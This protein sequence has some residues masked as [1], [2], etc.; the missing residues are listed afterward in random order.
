ML[1]VFVIRHLPPLKINS[2]QFQSLNK[3][4]H[5]KDLLYLY[6]VAVYLNSEIGKS[7]SLRGE[8][9]GLQKHITLGRTKK[10]PIYLLSKELQDKIGYLYLNSITIMK[11]AITK[12]E[13]AENK[14]ISEIGLNKLQIKEEKTFYG[15]FND[16]E[17]FERIDADFFQPKYDE[18]INKIT[19]YKNGYSI[20]DK[21]FK[22]NKD[23]F[24]RNEDFIYNY[25]EIGSVNIFDVKINP[26]VK[27]YS[28]LPDNCKIKLEKNNLLISKVRPYRGA[29]SIIEDNKENLVGSTAFTI[30]KEKTKYKKE[31]LLLLLRT[32]FYKELMMKY[33]VGTSYPVVK[34]DNIVNLPI[35]LIPVEVQNEL[36]KEINDFFKL[37]NEAEKNLN[38][39]KSLLF[40]EINKEL[41]L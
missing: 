31:I 32:S 16:I 27:K 7:L 12:Y 17:K 14:L 35:P 23:K 41:N 6:Y 11:E 38:D 10:I 29:I 1:Y 22:V 26:L 4:Q 36:S 3:Q 25:V 8:S 9:G 19:S 13:E 18:I 2:S 20:I 21:E 40:D 28:D 15:N 39:A 33:N 5:N 30:L 37:R 34:D 24:E